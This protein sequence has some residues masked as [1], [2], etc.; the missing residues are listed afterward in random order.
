MKSAIKVKINELNEKV[1]LAEKAKI[2]AD[3]S[4]IL[5]KIPGVVFYFAFRS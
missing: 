1:Q 4:R 3:K 2:D 5:N